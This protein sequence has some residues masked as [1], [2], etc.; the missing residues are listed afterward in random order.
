MLIKPGLLLSPGRKKTFLE[1]VKA[2]L[3]GLT[4]VWYADFVNN[5]AIANSVDVGAVS[6]IPNLTGTLNLVATGHRLATTANILAI[7]SVTLAYPFTLWAEFIKTANAVT[8]KI[9]VQA[10]FG[11]TSQNC[12]RLNIDNAERPTAFIN[13]TNVGQAQVAVS[14]TTD[15]SSKYKAAARYGTNDVQAAS[16]NLLGTQ[17]TVVSPASGPDQIHIGG[18]PTATFLLTGDIARYAIFNF[19]ATDAELQRLTT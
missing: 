3:G 8:D 4:P 15:T 7:T 5:R 14:V 18:T 1:T 6:S 16:Q 12:S 10:S 17:D 13:N 9:L 11:A 2:S 19:A